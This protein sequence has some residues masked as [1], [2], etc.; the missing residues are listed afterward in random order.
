VRISIQDYYRLEIFAI[1]SLLFNYFSGL[2]F[3][4]PLIVF[5]HLILSF[6]KYINYYY[7]E[8]LLAFFQIF[9]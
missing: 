3:L 7:Y 9:I 4:M 2:V 5:F 6:P 1:I 8:P